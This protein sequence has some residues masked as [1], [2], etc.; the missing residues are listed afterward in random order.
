M[1]AVER[2]EALVIG[3]GIGGLASA[4]ALARKGR[5]VTVLER[6][7]QFAE[8]G[9]G[10]QL[11]P[12]A[13]RVLDQL[14]VLSEI[15]K[16]AVFPGAVR[17][18]DAMTGAE[19]GRLDLGHAFVERYGYRYC[20]MHRSDLLSVLL[21]ACRA[22]P[23]I[24]LLTDKA[25]TEVTDLDHAAEAACADGSVYRA[26][27]VI[28]ADGLWSRTRAILTGEETAPVCS[29][30]VAYRGTV[31]I[32]DMA[33]LGGDDDVMLW[34]GP[35]MH[36]VQ[37]PVRRGELYNQVAVFKSH[38]YDEGAEDWGNVEELEAR[39]AQ[40][41]DYVRNALTRIGK[42]QRWPLFDRPPLERWTKN[43]IALTG[44]AAHPMLQYLAQGAAQALEDAVALGEAVEAATDPAEALKVF[45]DR[46]QFRTARVQLTAHLFGE[47][48]HVGGVGAQ[49]RNAFVA[50][51]GGRVPWDWIDWIYSEP[52]AAAAQGAVVPSVRL[53]PA[54]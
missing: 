9:A 34:A 51:A 15:E 31:P 25:V 49:L 3:G 30:Y 48:C 8:V 20:V 27:M 21:D 38:R 32:A 19:V 36:L 11:G 35:E 37:Y 50:Q 18:M 1:A 28:G 5:A 4:L 14:G 23:S 42:N 33:G 2:I 17:M 29:R 22:E 52:A 47:I 6:A 40:G 7:P 16:Y 41:C 13:S 45:Q 53:A 24:T 43:R 39:F 26:D 54:A 12:N 44:D 46:R 10:L